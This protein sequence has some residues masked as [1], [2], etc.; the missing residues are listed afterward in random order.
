MK[1]LFLS[2]DGSL[3]PIAKRVE[4][5][6][7][8]VHFYVNSRKFQI[9]GRGE[10]KF[11]SNFIGVL[12]GPFSIV[13]ENIKQVIKEA[14]PD[15]CVANGKMGF[16]AEFVKEQGVQCVGASRWSELLEGEYAQRILTSVKV[17]PIKQP[18]K[19]IKVGVSGWWDGTTFLYPQLVAREL[20][21]M[22]N[23]G[24]IQLI[25]GICSKL[26]PTK[27]KLFSSTLGKLVEIMKKINYSGPVTLDT[28]LKAGIT[29]P[30]FCGLSEL[31][32]GST[33]KLLN[34]EQQNT[35]K[36]HTISLRVTLP[37]YP[38]SIGHPYIKE[39]QVDKKGEKHIWLV[40]VADNRV[41]VVDGDVGWVSA[42]GKRN[43]KK[44]ETWD[45]WR[46]TRRRVLRTANNIA[47]SLEEL[48]FRT[49][50][51][52]EGSKVLEGIRID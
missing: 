17:N 6:G 18:S 24:G 47:V 20:G 32:Q 37:P 30:I 39:I 34:G 26:I 16:V 50:I 38:S 22:N 29:L 10:V 23:G 1:V 36:K 15:L 40:D 11:R 25:S 12:H 7:H 31:T 33:L 41:G 21:F 42:S 2:E 49:D 28:E 44:S 45:V 51:G 48:Q 43:P 46:E 4:R 35:V 8:S 3:L 27:C 9:R 13:P 19:Q 52:E 5:E 14:Q